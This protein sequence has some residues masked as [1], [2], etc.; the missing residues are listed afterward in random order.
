[1]LPLFKKKKIGKKEGESIK[2]ITGWS[3]E[4]SFSQGRKSELFMHQDV[5][6]F[7]RGGSGVWGGGQKQNS[8]LDDTFSPLQFYI[9]NFFYW[10]SKCSFSGVCWGVILYLHKRK[11]QNGDIVQYQMGVVNRDGWYKEKT[12]LPPPLWLHYAL[13][14]NSLIKL[15]LFS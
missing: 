10:I 7:R 8:S 2:T 11:T 4:V 6:L 14:R 13:D 12:T 1:M 3:L 5:F 9:K 15:Y